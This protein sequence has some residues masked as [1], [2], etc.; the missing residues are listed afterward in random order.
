MCVAGGADVGETNSQG[1][2]PVG[3]LERTARAAASR[4]CR[5]ARHKP[6]P[7]HLPHPPCAVQLSALALQIA[8]FLSVSVNRPGLGG[9]A[10]VTAIRE[11]FDGHAACR[12]LQRLQVLQ[13][14]TGALHYRCGEPASHRGTSFAR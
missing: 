1:L 9:L 5:T 14:S 3:E 4:P 11:A 13:W 6:R 10:A 12:W 8:A 2:D 7:A